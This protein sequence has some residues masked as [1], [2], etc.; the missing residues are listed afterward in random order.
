[1]Q[2]EMCFP[3]S[4]VWGMETNKYILVTLDNLGL[5]KRKSPL[6]LTFGKTMTLSDVLHVSS[7]ELI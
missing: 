3:P 4:L 5:K 1:M 6:K 2:T 7:I